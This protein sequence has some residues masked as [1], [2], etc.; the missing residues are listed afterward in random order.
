MIDLLL[1]IAPDGR[2][3]GL[4]ALEPTPAP[5]H[6]CAVAP[7]PVQPF[8]DLL[9]EIALP[10]AVPVAFDGE[11]VQ[12]ARAALHVDPTASGD[13]E[14]REP[15]A[16]GPGHMAVGLPQ[17]MMALSNAAVAPAMPV[18]LPASSV[19]SSPTADTTPVSAGEGEPLAASSLATPAMSADPRATLA[20]AWSR[21]GAAPMERS[22]AAAAVAQ[23][24]A[25]GPRDLAAQVGLAAPGDLAALAGGGAPGT[26]LPTPAP[27]AAMPLVIAGPV[28]PASVSELVAPSNS[29]SMYAPAAVSIGAVASERTVPPEAPQPGARPSLAAALG[30]RLHVQ[31]TR[32]VEHAVVRLDP[33][34]LGTV[35]IVIRH[36]GG[37]LQVHLRATHAE[38][39]RQLQAIGETLRQDL[40][41]RQHGEVSVQVWERE[42]EGR[43]RPRQ[44]WQEVPGRAL[45][46]AGDEP[47]GAFALASEAHA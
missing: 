1:N 27:Q 14:L 24:G 29:A 15:V 46:E 6:A 47:E 23:A 39:T 43:Q 35:E 31:V 7:L 30:E 12:P 32:G 45:N 3:R 2:G 17:T 19:V 40:V 22:A 44:P 38:V 28:E 13:D 20:Q 41:Q 5:M 8:G 36:E 37:H 25:A 21:A 34:A 9:V 16:S 33:P 11:A 18:A 4:F 42:G 10:V 26:R